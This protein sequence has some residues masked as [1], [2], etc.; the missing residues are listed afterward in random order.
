[1]KTLRSAIA[2]IVGP[3][4]GERGQTLMIFALLIVPISFALGVVA[5]GIGVTLTILAE[6]VTPVAVEAQP[7]E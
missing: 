1:M 3:R 7:L 2:H 4:S 5:I 6:R